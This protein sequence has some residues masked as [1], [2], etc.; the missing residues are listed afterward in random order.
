M[1]DW[2]QYDGQGA[3]IWSY[4][5]VIKVLDNE[6]T[7]ILGCPINPETKS[8]LDRGITLPDNNQVFLGEDNPLATSCTVHVT[9]T[10]RLSEFC[11]DEVTYDVKIFPFNGPD[12]LQIHEKRTVQMDT[13]GFADAVIDTRSSD[14]L[15]VR[16]NGL[17]YNSNVCSNW[18]LPGG[19]KDYHRVLITVEDGCGNVNACEYLLRLEDKKAPSPV[20]V[21]LSSVVMPSSGEVTIWAKDF[22]ASSFDDCTPAADL[23]YS[24]SG[25]NYEP[26][27]SFTCAD[28]AENGSPSFI[29]EIYVA[30]KGN[31][32]NC[33]GFRLPGQNEGIT[34]GI[35]WAE[36][37]KD[38]CTTFIV[39][40]DNENVCSGTGGSAGGVISTEELE[41]VEKVNVNLKDHNGNVVTS[42][43]TDKD[44]IYHFINPLLDL[45]IEPVRNDD[46][47]NG[48]STLDLVK[49]QKHLLGIEDLGSPYKLIAADANNSSSVSA[50]DLV[51]LRKLILGLYNELPNNSSWRFA[52]GSYE[53][54]DE[55]N[56]WDF[57]E[58]VNI[59]GLAMDKDFV[60]IKIGD[61]NG[62][63]SANSNSIETR[64]VTGAMKFQAVDQTVAAGEEVLVDVTSSDFTNIIGYQFTLQTAGLKLTDVVAGAIDMGIENVGIHKNS[65][66][67]S[68]NRV[69]AV[70]AEADDVL[71]TLAFTATNG[72]QLSDMLSINSRLTEAEAYDE[73]E[74]ILDVAITFTTEEVA[75]AGKDF[76][77]FQN[78]PNPFNGETVIAFTLPEAMEATLTVFDVTG[79]VVYLTEGD[80]AAGYNNVTVSANDLSATGV[81]YY[82]LD[83]D[84]FTA[85]K[86]M[87]L[88]D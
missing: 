87:V 44:G 5:Q 83:A 34:D 80:Y 12:F 55:A 28:L 17:P 53:F 11:S 13:N 42:F 4:V 52:D 40:D 76:A 22:N 66:T 64:N 70:S 24:F 18:P 16:L 48:V 65:V 41:P 49:I 77:L 81:L 57:V 88:I 75:Q 10:F 30:D 31:D 43:T 50:I 9:D 63:V 20:C 32:D 33:N 82:R 37:N 84:D 29:V 46:H 54:A 26:S 1:I 38:F 61:V 15:G 47:K 35:E 78:S 86:K 6:P 14:I 73:S 7:F 69:T 25:E 74:N 45:D 39:I 67:A 21:G 71:F 85:T 56:P 19:D 3:G 68:W 62:T 79:K 59:Q 60:A 2:C 36:R 58:V 51:E 8:V 27:R 72:G 23:L